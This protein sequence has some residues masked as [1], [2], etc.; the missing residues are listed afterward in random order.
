MPTQIQQYMIGPTFGKGYHCEIRLATDTLN[1]QIV[2][3][4]SKKRAVMIDH[5]DMEDLETL[6]I[7]NEMNVLK[8]LSEGGGHKHVIKYIESG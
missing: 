4:K 6:E 8:A 5:Q 2:A 7:R 3:L 1:D